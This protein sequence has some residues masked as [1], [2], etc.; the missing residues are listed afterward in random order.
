MC[1]IGFRSDR[2]A[3]FLL[4]VLLMLPLTARARA[5]APHLGGYPYVKRQPQHGYPAPMILG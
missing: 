4:G 1:P 3:V 5:K 2:Y